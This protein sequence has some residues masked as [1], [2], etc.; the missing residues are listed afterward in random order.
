MGMKHRCPNPNC[1]TVFTD[2]DSSAP[3]SAIREQPDYKALYEQAVEQLRLSTPLLPK[4]PEA[5]L[6]KNWALINA[7]EPRVPN[8]EYREL[9]LG[10]APAAPSTEA[11]IKKCPIHGTNLDA[12][13]C[14]TCD[15]EWP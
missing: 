2:L 15:P 10:G 12:A 11:A 5:L 4:W 8:G 14:R 13:G 6:K 3:R 7:S 1:R 9:H